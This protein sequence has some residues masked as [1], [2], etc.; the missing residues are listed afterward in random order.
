MSLIDKTSYAR[1]K[2]LFLQTK[3]L[4]WFEQTLNAKGGDASQSAEWLDILKMSCQDGQWAMVEAIH[5]QYHG[6]LVH[7]FINITEENNLSL[8]EKIVNEGQFEN[9]LQAGDYT[10]LSIMCVLSDKLTPCSIEAL[11]WV[12]TNYRKLQ[13]QEG[14]L[15]PQVSVVLPYLLPGTRPLN[16]DQGLEK[17]LVNCL[18]G[19]EYVDKNSLVNLV[20]AFL[21]VQ[22]GSLDIMKDVMEKLDKDNASYILEAFDELKPGEDFEFLR[23][24]RAELLKDDIQQELGAQELDPI[25]S[26]RR[27]I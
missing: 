6:A 15:S 14:E 17:E 12:Y 2:E 10:P 24:R 20:G 13:Q 23:K 16:R 5:Q 3:E 26:K 11:K 9:F 7:L 8:F 1:G 4:V 25:P 22:T 21:T 27:V 19:R 18:F